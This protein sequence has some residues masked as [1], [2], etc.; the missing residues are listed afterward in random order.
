MFSL[1][2]YLNGVQK[3]LLFP[4][5]PL[6]SLKVVS[7]CDYTMHAGHES[8]EDS[9]SVFQEV[10]GQDGATVMLQSAAPGAGGA[11]A[12]HPPGGLQ[13]DRCTRPGPVLTALPRLSPLQ[14]PLSYILCC[15]SHKVVVFSCV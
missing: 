12:A 8:G 15:C 3:R 10:L 11:D 2:F 4:P 9:V 5:P 1:T 7:V 13:E 6:E 14:V